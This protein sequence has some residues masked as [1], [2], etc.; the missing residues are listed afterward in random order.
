MLNASVAGQQS[1]SVQ[2]HFIFV[3]I[4]LDFTQL[5]SIVALGEVIGKKPI[6]TLKLT[7]NWNR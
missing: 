6:S 4:G 5:M 7:L 2:L 1:I 3:A